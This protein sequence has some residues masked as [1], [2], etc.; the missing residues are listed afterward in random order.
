M[1]LVQFIS[2]CRGGDQ[3]YKIKKLQLR[4]LFSVQFVIVKL[5]MSKQEKPQVGF[6]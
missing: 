5:G 2:L 6:I 4:K 3:Q 1:W